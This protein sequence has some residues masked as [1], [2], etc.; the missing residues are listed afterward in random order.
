M[1]AAQAPTILIS[2]SGG[3]DSAAVLYHQLR[4]SSKRVLVHHVNRTNTV[5]TRSGR[6]PFERHAVSAVLAWLRDQGL[7]HFE[8]A[9]TG[10]SQDLPFVDTVC[11]ALW[12]GVV[13]KRHKQID[14][15]IWPSSLS[16]R[17]RLPGWAENEA[18]R[19]QLVGLLCGRNLR[20]VDPNAE[21][22]KAEVMAGLPSDLLALTWSC[23]TPTLAG[24]PCGEC[25]ACQGI[26]VKEVSP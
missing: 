22:T 18:K 9:E 2:F 6:E 25:H 26:V 12:A 20:W 5:R 16:D 14:T 21:L 17:T 1:T 15:V 23:R 10:M 19:R 8:F 3:I 13:L 7:D 24:E 4:G 11:V